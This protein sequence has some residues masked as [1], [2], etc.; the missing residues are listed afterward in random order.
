[1]G[2]CGIGVVVR[3]ICEGL[4]VTG[5]CV[6][7]VLVYRGWSLCLVFVRAGIYS[8]LWEGADRKIHDCFGV[9]PSHLTRIGFH[10]IIYIRNQNRNKG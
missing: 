9:T 6:A 4:V 2:L 7:C 8:I 10:V 5:L 3:G 1:M